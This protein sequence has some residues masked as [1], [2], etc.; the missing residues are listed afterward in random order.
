MNQ[1][2]A[3]AGL[4]LELARAELPEYSHLKSPKKFIQPQLLACL[5]L[6]AYQKSAVSLHGRI[7]R[8]C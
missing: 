5:V 1:L 8:L 2:E 7:V 4:A 3:I 6:K